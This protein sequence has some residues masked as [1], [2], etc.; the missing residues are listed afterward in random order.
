M[1]LAIG[2]VLSRAQTVFNG[3]QSTDSGP[4]KGTGQSAAVEEAQETTTQ[5]RQEASRGDQVA[6]RRLAAL[7]TSGNPQ[8]TSTTTSTPPPKADDGK[9]QLVS[10]I[11]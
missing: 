3:A 9:G 10:A 2:G 11:A 6:I 1:G 5:T 7:K 4:S 8:S